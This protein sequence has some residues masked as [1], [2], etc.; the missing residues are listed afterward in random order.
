ML[1][2]RPTRTQSR[3][4][5]SLLKVG[6]ALERG[7]DLFAFGKPFIANPDLPHRIRHD[8]PWN[9]VDPATMYGGTAHGYTDYPTYEQQVQQSAPEPEGVS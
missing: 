4:S 5:V 9:K 3:R 7:G 8:L 6:T 2:S 1:G